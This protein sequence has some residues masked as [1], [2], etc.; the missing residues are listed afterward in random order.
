[1]ARL[2]RA[3]VN[4]RTALDEYRFN[5]AASELYAFVWHELCDWY[6]ELSKGT[7][8]N[9]EDVL[10]QQGARKTLL[11][12]FNAVVRLMHPIIEESSLS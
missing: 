3:I 1:M 5:E 10:A 8:Y 4:I 11:E 2:N 12:V 7:L 6:V 9:G